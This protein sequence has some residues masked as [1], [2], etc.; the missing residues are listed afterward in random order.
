MKRICLFR[1]VLIPVA[2]FLAV[3]QVRDAGAAPTDMAEAP[4]GMMQALHAEM[5]G[6]PAVP[7]EHLERFPKTPRYSCFYVDGGR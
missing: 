7:V 3:I 5:E 6:A 2:V 1:G 4:E